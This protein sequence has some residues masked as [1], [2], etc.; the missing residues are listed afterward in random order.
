MVFFICL[1]TCSGA[2][3]ISMGINSRQTLNWVKIW[4]KMKE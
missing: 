4:K 3:Q 1:K 2:K